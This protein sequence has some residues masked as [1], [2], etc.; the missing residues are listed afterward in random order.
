MASC[1]ASKSVTPFAQIPLRKVSGKKVSRTFHTATHP[2]VEHRSEW[3]QLTHQIFH[4]VT[5]TSTYV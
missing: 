3:T 5:L 4:S 2:V 1:K